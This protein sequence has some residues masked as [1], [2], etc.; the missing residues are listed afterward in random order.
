[1]LDGIGVRV[2]VRDRSGV[3]VRVGVLVAVLVVVGVGVAVARPM[4]AEMTSEYSVLLLVS[5]ISST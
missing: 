4:V 2:G 5:M 1:M 3:F